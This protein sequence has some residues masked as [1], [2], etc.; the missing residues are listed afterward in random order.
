MCKEERSKCCDPENF[1][2]IADN[3]YKILNN[4]VSQGKLMELGVFPAFIL[5][6]EALYEGAIDNMGYDS[7]S[8]K[9]YDEK[10][11]FLRKLLM[12]E[13]NKLNNETKKL[14]SNFLNTDNEELIS[15]IEEKIAK[16]IPK[17]INYAKVAE[18]KSKIN[19]LEDLMIE[20][21]SNYKK[22]KSLFKTIFKHLFLN[23]FCNV[24]TTANSAQDII[25]KS[26]EMEEMIDMLKAGS[27]TGTII[28]GFYFITFIVLIIC[29]IFNI[30]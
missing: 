19:K 7:L 29:G 24:V 30:F 4:K 21:K 22:G 6:N 3:V 27:A 1:I 17:E 16:N 5:F 8:N 25:S 9:N 14:I 23:I 12:D 11:I 2:E 18:L 13:T 10:K 15:T 26:G 28:A 20:K